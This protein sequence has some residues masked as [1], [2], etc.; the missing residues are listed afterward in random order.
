MDDSDG[1]TCYFKRVGQDDCCC[2]LENVLEER[3]KLAGSY[4]KSINIHR[5][6]STSI[7]L[8]IDR[9]IQRIDNWK[10]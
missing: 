7:T 9:D 3:R 8:S 6:P 10:Q 1:G 4:H 2:E 5:P